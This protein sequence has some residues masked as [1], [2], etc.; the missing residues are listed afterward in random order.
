M[1]YEWKELRTRCEE[2][3]Q[4]QISSS[5]TFVLP[6]SPRTKEKQLKEQITRQVSFEREECPPNLKPGDEV[7]FKYG[8][9]MFNYTIPDI[10]P[11]VAWWICVF[12]LILL[13]WTDS[14]NWRMRRKWR[15]RRR[16]RRGWAE[17]NVCP[18]V[19]PDASDFVDFM[20]AREKLR[21]NKAKYPDDP[22]RTQDSILREFKFTNVKREHDHNDC[23]QKD[24]GLKKTYVSSNRRVVA[25]SSPDKTRAVYESEI[26]EAGLNGIQL[27]YMACVR[28]VSINSRKQT[29]LIYSR[30]HLEHNRYKDSLVHRSCWNGGIHYRVGSW[31]D[32]SYRKVVH[33]RLVKDGNLRSLLHIPQSIYRNAEKRA[34]FHNNPELAIRWHREMCKR[35]TNVWNIRDNIA[36]LAVRQSHENSCGMSCKV[37][38]VR[39]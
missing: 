8:D 31:H 25:S 3:L 23:I 28:V 1:L 18:W 19:H 12:L 20:I 13:N 16:K 37:C 30:T 6:P 24:H 9:R 33:R 34:M 32:R 5:E 17:I 26:R 27:L 15:K 10:F 29:R 21:I 14:H 11:R 35:L 4:K 7:M 2:K 36:R 22:Q 39:W 38:M